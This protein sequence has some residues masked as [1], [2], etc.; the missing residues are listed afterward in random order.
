MPTLI[1]L[2]GLSTLKEIQRQSGTLQVLQAKRRLHHCILAAGI[3]CG[4]RLTTEDNCGPTWHQQPRHSNQRH[5]QHRLSL[6]QGK[7]RISS[8]FHSWLTAAHHH[9]RHLLPFNPGWQPR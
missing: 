3:L 5:G 8:I 7:Q 1:E 2:M 9:Q 4:N 6:K